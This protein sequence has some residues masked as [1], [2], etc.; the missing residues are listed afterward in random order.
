[1][2]SE[3]KADGKWRKG[4]K[5]ETGRNWSRYSLGWPAMKQQRKSRWFCSRTMHQPLRNNR[6]KSIEKDVEK[7]KERRDS[8]ATIRK[9]E[10]KKERIL[11]KNLM[12][13]LLEWK[14]VRNFNIYGTKWNAVS[15]L[16]YEF[17]CIYLLKYMN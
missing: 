1:M 8:V 6:E 2:G 5:K 14:K 11:G 10:K 17:K 16:K 4:W 15:N 12:T 7:M 13:D 3:A 9:R